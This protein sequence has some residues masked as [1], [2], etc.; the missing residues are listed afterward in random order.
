LIYGKSGDTA[1]GKELINSALEKNPA[2]NEQ[3]KREAQ[4]FVDG[5]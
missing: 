3:L 1:K 5:K 4:K 2:I